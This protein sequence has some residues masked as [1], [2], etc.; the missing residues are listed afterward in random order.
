MALATWQASPIVTASDHAYCGLAQERVG[1]HSPLAPAAGGGHL[2]GACG[3]LLGPAAWAF[4]PYE[5]ETLT[6]GL[7][8]FM[9]NWADGRITDEAGHERCES[10]CWEVAA[11]QARTILR[12]TGRS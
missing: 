6:D 3:R 4:P 5:I 7:R 9:I 1:A 11:A 2:Y 12:E 8:D 10:F